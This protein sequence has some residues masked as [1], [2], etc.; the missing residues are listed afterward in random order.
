MGK[1]AALNGAVGV[2][3]GDIL[4]F[5]DSTG[6][7]NRES[8]REMVANFNDPSVGC[9]T[10]RVTYRYGS[11]ATSKGFK[12]Y[13]RIAVAIRRA[14]SVFGSQTSVSGSI[15]AIRRELLKA[16]NASRARKD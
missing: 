15:H 11:D 8:I 1:T 7:Y 6:I 16:T 5:S 12:G 13:Q 10:G 14:E 9:V 2:A 3:T 4:L